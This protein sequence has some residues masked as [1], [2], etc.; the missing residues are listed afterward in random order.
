MK[1]REAMARELY[2]RE[3]HWSW[4]KWEDFENE[5]LKENQFRKGA[6]N[7]LSLKADGCRLAIVREKRD[8]DVTWSCPCD[9]CNEIREEVFKVHYVQEEVDG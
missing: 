8:A 1:I 5:V 4:P 3:K 7:I 2:K 6:D 9:M